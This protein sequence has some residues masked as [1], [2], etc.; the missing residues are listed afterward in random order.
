[1]NVIVLDCFEVSLVVMIV[2]VVIVD[3]CD[4]C[5]W[6]FVVLLFYRVFVL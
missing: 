4:V 5:V 2:V 3:V 6:V 1:M